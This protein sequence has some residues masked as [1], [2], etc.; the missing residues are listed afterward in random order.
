M[1]R[2]QE[3][4]QGDEMIEMVETRVFSVRDKSL[5]G[6]GIFALFS[7][8]EMAQCFLDRSTG[9][10]RQCGEVAELTIIGRSDA[11]SR[12]F[13]AYAY[14]DLYDSLIFE[15]LYQDAAL[16]TDVAGHKGR[17]VELLIDSPLEP[18]TPP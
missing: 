11:S 8:H 13:A 17:I 15:G 7:T 4:L 1:S 2:V 3:I 18:P 6:R 10:V 9:I 14:D 12:V 5:L 16:A